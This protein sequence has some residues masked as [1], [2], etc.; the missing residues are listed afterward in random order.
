MQLILKVISKISTFARW[1]FTTFLLLMFI[2]LTFFS[3]IVLDCMKRKCNS[4]ASMNQFALD[5]IVLLIDVL[6]GR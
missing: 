1:K 4:R 2:R 5:I 6:R 3:K